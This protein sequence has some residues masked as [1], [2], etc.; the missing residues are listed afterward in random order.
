MRTEALLRLVCGHQALTP[1]DAVAL[2]RARP[3]GSTDVA[4]AHRLEPLLRWRLGALG[5]EDLLTDRLKQADRAWMLRSLE[6]QAQ[7]VRATR[8]LSSHG[9]PHAFL[10]G[11]FLAFHAY[12][13]PRLRPTR[14]L[15]VLVP[16]ADAVHAFNALLKGGF[17]RLAE[18]QGDADAARDVAHHLPPLR[19]SRGMVTIEVH[20]RLYAR[21]FHLPEPA[22]DPDFWQR[23]VHRPVGGTLVP[24]ESP[25]DLLLHLVLHAA[26]SHTL[27][28]GPLLL[29]DVAFLVQ[30][31]PIDWPALWERAHVAGHTRTVALVLAMVERFSGVSLPEGHCTGAPAEDVPTA[32]MS[33]AV[34]L[35]VAVDRN[36]D[37]ERLEASPQRVARLTHLVHFGIRSVCRSRAELAAVYP[38]SADS[39]RIYPYYLVNAWWLLTDRLPAFGLWFGRRRSDSISDARRALLHWIAGDGRREDTGHRVVT[40]A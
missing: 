13:A 17:E 25:T 36:R 29:T 28:N 23:V 40:E 12:P 35:L 32:V 31:E 2:I 24:Y 3:E 15:D 34:R 10:K 19:S 22:V 38:V 14:D 6:T 33:D 26:V 11:A 30:R 8:I 4:R 9:I 21:D 16:H 37:F 1:A 39:W 5:C 18:H 7:L 20:V 27:D